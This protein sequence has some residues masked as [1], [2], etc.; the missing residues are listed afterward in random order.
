MAVNINATLENLRIALEENTAG[1]GEC[2]A[3]GG[4]KTG[5]PPSEEVPEYG[6]P[7]DKYP[8]AES[9]FDARCN[10]ANA[11]YDT[12]LGSIEWFD[13]NHIDLKAGALGG[14]TTGLVVMALSS[15]PVGWALVAGS[16]VVAGMAAWVVAEILDF[17]ELAQSLDNVHDDLVS[18]LYNAQDVPT[19][20]ANFIEILGGATPDPDDNVL[21]LI[22]LMLNE[23]VL[24]Q[25]FNPRSDVATYVSPDPVDCGGVIV[26]W[27][28]DADTESWTFRDDS[29]ANAS[30]VGSYDG[31]NEALSH[32]QIIVAGGSGRVTR[33]VDVSPVLA[34]VVGA[35]NSVQADHD[36]VSDG[37]VVSRKLT[38]T[39]TDTSEYVAVKPGHI[40]AGTIILSL[41][42]PGTIEEIELETSRSNGASST[43]YSFTTKTLEVRIQ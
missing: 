5:S 29:T 36:A 11:V 21:F 16:T 23:D 41:T 38:V 30:A 43:G 22:Q 8:D 6:N 34:Q 17:E 37:I 42:E 19:A 24:N 4:S 18:A 32:A 35:G 2:C 1:A 9:F 40:G 27:D 10:G 39:Y 31:T 14:L 33:A 13:D 28:F 25:V 7:G 26:R 12:I 3:A 20:R 15:G